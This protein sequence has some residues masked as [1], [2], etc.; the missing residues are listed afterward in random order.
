MKYLP[1]H[2]RVT[3]ARGRTAIKSEVCYTGHVLSVRVQQARHIKHRLWTVNCTLWT[4]HMSTLE[5]VDNIPFFK[6][7][8]F[9]ENRWANQSLTVILF[10]GKSKF[11]MWVPWMY[12]QKQQLNVSYW[13]VILLSTQ[14]LFLLPSPWMK[15]L[16]DDSYWALFLC[17]ASRRCSKGG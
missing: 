8:Y 15:P 7:H 11:Q 12:F 13:S 1:L 17:S 14:C 3:W 9:N 16:K 10:I 2:K 6:R 5:V 4:C